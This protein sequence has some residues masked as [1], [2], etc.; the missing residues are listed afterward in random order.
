MPF[1]M[2]PGAMDI[3]MDSTFA[4]MQ[5]QDVTWEEF[6]VKFNG[7]YFTLDATKGKEREF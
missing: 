3:F 6:R 4:D 5:P 1:R 2:R 7:K